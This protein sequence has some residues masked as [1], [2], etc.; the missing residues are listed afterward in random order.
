[1]FQLKDSFLRDMRDWKGNAGRTCEPIRFCAVGCTF[2]IEHSMVIVT[3]KIAYCHRL[4][5][6]VLRCNDALSAF[7]FVGIE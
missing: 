3:T 2:F 7:E 5:K 6:F 1:L 4:Q